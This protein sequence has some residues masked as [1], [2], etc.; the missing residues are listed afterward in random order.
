MAYLILVRHGQSEYN[1]KGLW[2]GWID[3]PLTELGREE[4]RAAGEA[5]HDI[6]L[7]VVFTTDL[8]RAQDTWKEMSK[9]LGKESLPVTIAPELKER[10]YGDM[11][12]LN[13][14]DVKEKYGEEQWMSWRRGWDT[15]IPN[16]ETLKIVYERTVPYYQA[17]ILPLIEQ[18][19]NVIISAHGNSLRALVKYLDHISDED[20]QKLE[21]PTGGIYLYNIDESGKIVSKELRAASEN[22]A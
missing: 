19:K 20:V 11:A 17:H 16:G 1:E 9:V 15:P 22:K 7:D 5:L 4:A 14:W 3:S 13:K 8:V 2:C 6:P 18:G 10:S 21:I 12:G